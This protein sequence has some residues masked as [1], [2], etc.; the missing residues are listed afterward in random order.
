[1]DG[2]RDYSITLPRDVAEEIEAKVRSG[3]YASV[4]EVVGDGVRALMDRDAGIERWL[5]DEV[6]P[7]HAEYLADPSSA[8]PVEDVLPRIKSRKG[9]LGKGPSNADVE[10]RDCRRQ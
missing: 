8:V 4:S 3:A 10:N 1:M 5:R 2:T 7:G 6:L 9:L